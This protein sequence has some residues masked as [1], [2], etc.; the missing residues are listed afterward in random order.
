MTLRE[1]A[2][3]VVFTRLGSNMPPPVT[4]AEDR[5]RVA[6][7]LDRCPLGGL[8]LFNGDL[9]TT[10]AHLEALQARVDVPLLVAADIER[11][12]GQQLRGA[13]VFPH[14]R[15]F[16]ALGEE[17]EAAVEAAARATAREARAAG[18]HITF[19]P[20]AD[21]NLDPHNP[22]IAI[23]AFGEE[24]GAV[25]RLVQAYVRG[26][27]AG[28]LLTAAKHFPGHGNTRRD[29]HAE[30]PVVT[31]GR[32]TLLRT[33]LVPFRAAI[34]A[35]VDLMMT[36]HVAFPALDPSGR[37]ATASRPIL[38]DLLRD[39]L[40]FDGAVITDSLLMGAI[41]DAYPD[42][43]AQA[44][45]LVQAGVDILLDQPDPE[46]AVD[47]LVRA[48]EEG[49]LAEAR[50]EEAV[51]RVQRLRQRAFGAGGPVPDRAVP[52]LPAHQALARRLARRAVHVRA[53]G[54]GLLPLDPERAAREGML[55]VLVQPHR[56]RL[57][58]PE[59]PLGAALRA[60]FPGVTYAEVGPETE[61]AR[62]RAL[63]QQAGSAAY[64][65]LALVVKPAA[66]H[67]FGLTPR[68]QR[69]VASLAARPGVVLAALGSPVVLEAFPQAAARLCTYSDV[70]VSQEALVAVLREGR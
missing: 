20:V 18:V 8:V 68:Q 36:A 25:A 52:D 63:A 22:I 19:G 5:D 24:P 27:R 13:T 2:A 55:A 54:T 37:P 48:V 49:R 45:A 23:R 50:L 17:A 12:A 53:A 59:Q 40:G 16:G 47:G 69:F 58:P 31:S 4:V 32:D 42:A 21:V 62:Y 26:A 67:A 35:G 51:G 34:E 28:G 1:K 38:H 70:P 61:E 57:D 64:V 14:A 7:L 66:W 11:G 43:G 44:V 10:P 29:S 33:D 3:Q 15:A 56:S 30:L 60:A 9:A 41:R 46:G 65:L 39:E 6:A